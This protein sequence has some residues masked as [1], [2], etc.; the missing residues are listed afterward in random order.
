M[1][2]WDGVTERRQNNTLLEKKIEEIHKILCGNGKLG[3]CSKVEIMW[4]T[5]IFLVIGFA[6]TVGV[7]LWN[8]LIHQ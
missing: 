5:T 4:N 2:E 6:T 8:V 7:Y 3:L 1:E